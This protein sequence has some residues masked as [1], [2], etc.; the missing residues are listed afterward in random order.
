MLSR[1][2]FYAEEIKI[3]RAIKLWL[4]RNGFIINDVPAPGDDKLKTCINVMGC[5]RIGLIISA[6]IREKLEQSKPLRTL[7]IDSSCDKH[8]AHPIERRQPGRVEP[9]ETNLSCFDDLESMSTKYQTVNNKC[10]IDVRN[11]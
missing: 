1:D 5:L 10:T 11:F 4:V 2:T 9:E 3:F 7:F 6:D 8:T